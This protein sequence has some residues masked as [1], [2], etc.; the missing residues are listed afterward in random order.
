MSA[1]LVDK[2]HIDLIVGATEAGADPVVA[3]KVGR[4][5]WVENLRSVADRYP[6]DR[7]GG[8]PGPNG[9]RDT[10]IFCYV[11]TEQP[12]RL[13]PSQLKYALECLDYQSCEHDEWPA[14]E[15]HAFIERELELLGEMPDPTYGSEEAG[16]W[17]WDQEEV[18]KRAG[19]PALATSET[20]GAQ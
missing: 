11:Y 3:T 5:L 20:E 13:T 8:R 6:D 15:A 14:S 10:Q 7:S 4:M 1:W 2:V 9:L 12:Y 17:G 19:R 18:D 16:P